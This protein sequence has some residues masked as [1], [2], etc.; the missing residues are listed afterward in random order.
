MSD[1][2]TEQLRALLDDAIR[3]AR[4][5]AMVINSYRHHDLTVR[6]KGEGTL[7]STVVTEVD[8]KSQAAVMEVLTHSM[9]KYDLA[10]LTE[11]TPDNGTRLKKKA[12]W[13]VDPLDGTLP[14]IE[15]KPGYSVSISLIS[16][17]AVPLVGVIL[18]PEHEQLYTAVDGGGAFR[19]GERIQNN[20]VEKA[21]VL[22]VL[23]DRSAAESND[24]TRMT[25][26]ANQVADT[27]GY[28]SVDIS[29]Y[30]G[31]AMNAIVALMRAP[32]CYFKFPRKGSSGG[33]LW[34][35]GA[36]ACIYREAGAVATDLA[37]APL[38]LNRPDSTYMNHRGFI[39]ATDAGIARAL[40]KHC[41]ALRY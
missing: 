12:F 24:V 16:K 36:T 30:G 22:T 38:D 10:A 1:F 13:C 25:R 5:A 15:K 34:D 14:F 6:I 27:C 17:S 32:G 9:K 26:I 21:D 7:A 37:G 4:E 2:T 28:A 19:N 8:L 3:A 41:E 20:G 18:D 29:N 35:Y 11:E 39:Y 33:S 31:A 40:Q 23:I